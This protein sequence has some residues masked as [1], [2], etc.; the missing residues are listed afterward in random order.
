M[1]LNPK[2]LAELIEAQ[3]RCRIKWDYLGMARIHEDGT[4][5][6]GTLI[7]PEVHERIDANYTIVHGYRSIA[8]GINWKEVFEKADI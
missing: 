7:L 8:K 6:V 4:K 5:E 1:K 3:R 2:Q